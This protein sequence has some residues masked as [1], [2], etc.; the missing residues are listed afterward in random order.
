MGYRVLLGSVPRFAAELLGNA[1]MLVTQ[2]AEVIQN[3]YDKY[4]SISLNLKPTARDNYLKILENLNSA[5]VNKL[6]E[7][8]GQ[9][10]SKYS[11]IYILFKWRF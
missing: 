3:A 9:A 4:S 5:E 10:D 8:I 6:G 11:D 1:A 7:I 2:P